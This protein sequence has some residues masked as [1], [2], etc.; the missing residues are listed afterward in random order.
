MLRQVPS[1]VGVVLLEAGDERLGPGK[2]HISPPRM[3]CRLLH[4]TLQLTYNVLLLTAVL[5][6]VL[7]VQG[8]AEHVGDAGDAPPE[9]E[10]GI[11]GRLSLADFRTHFVSRHRRRRH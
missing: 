10:G 4:L 8:G 3:I 9:A 5:E 1:R 11:R 7:L 2:S 6:S